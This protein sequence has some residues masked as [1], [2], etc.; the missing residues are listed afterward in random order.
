MMLAFK[1]TIVYSVFNSWF[2][3]CEDFSRTSYYVGS[4]TT[5]VMGNPGFIFI[6]ILQ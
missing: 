6:T 3:D 1:D 2:I 5:C 4:Y